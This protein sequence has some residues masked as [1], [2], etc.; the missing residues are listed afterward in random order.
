MRDRDFRETIDE[1]RAAGDEPVPRHFFITEERTAR[2]TTR[3][4]AL[5]LAALAAG[6]VVVALAAALFSKL[7]VRAEN[8]VVMFAL[9]EDP[10]ERVL[11]PLEDRILESARAAARAD[12]EEWLAR[13]RSEMRDAD[14][15]ISADQKRTLIGALHETDRTLLHM[16]RV[17]D[18]RR[19]SDMA[20][21]QDRLEQVTTN[22][23]ARGRE[24]S[25][26]LAALYTPERT[27][28]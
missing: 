19:R 9:G 7:H 8:G 5:P 17:L 26:I 14:T 22:D 18:A 2:T 4:L 6:L 24:N 20:F 27:E 3:R 16:Y 25:L 21:V 13:V 10:V 12:D 11:A 28:R 15:K 23:E 1:L